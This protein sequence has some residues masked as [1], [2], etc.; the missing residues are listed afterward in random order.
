MS[1]DGVNPYAPPQVANESVARPEPLSAEQVRRRLIV[2]AMGILLS[3]V[4]NAT[5]IVWT[6]MSIVL[7]VAYGEREWFSLELGWSV[8]V[9][10]V[11]CV[12]NSLAARGAVAML[13]LT[14]YRTAIRGAWF[15]IVPCGI[16]CVVA[17]PFAIWA[18]VLLRD[19][20]VHAVFSGEKLRFLWRG[21]S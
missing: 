12:V 6:V 7:F 18:D 5:T 11:T 10:V 9:I 17:A 8:V 15:A 19:P 1:D 14:D 4:I 3:V 20:R 2:P 21:K 13:Q 16:G